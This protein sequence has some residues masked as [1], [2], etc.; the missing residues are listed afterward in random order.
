M[1]VFSIQLCELF[2]LTV[3]GLLIRTTKTILL[4][5]LGLLYLGFL[6]LEFENVTRHS[7]AIRI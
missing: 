5:I 6:R 2:P 4:Y 7:L 3:E 1:L